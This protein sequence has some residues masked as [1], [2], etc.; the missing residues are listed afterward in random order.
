MN[1][2][3]ILKV[4]IF[5]LV[6]AIINI[7]LFSPGFIGIKIGGT[8]T[9]T[10]A[11]GA[12]AVLM[13]IV[14]FIFGNYKLL[15]EKERVLRATEIKSAED[16]IYALEQN[17]RKKTFT[18]DIG[19]ILEQIGRFQKKKESIKDILLQKFNKNEMTYSK[20]LGTVSEVE[21]VFFLNIRS[22]LNKINAFDEEDYNYIRKKALEIKP[23]RDF[24]EEKMTIYNEYLA[25]TKNS[26]ED[27]EQV[28]LKLDR[29]LLEISKFNSLEDGEIEN[30]SAMREID[31]LINKVKLY[32]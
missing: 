22:I 27:N 28:L 15:T 20:F 19:V 7:V 10:T 23:S 30:M 16:Y 18:R 13:S 32:K 3:K 25:F 17:Y 21:S 29:L 8:S 26:I 6:I 9:F 12:T 31:E 5:S 24:I 2:K 4:A 14:V 1:S 11:F